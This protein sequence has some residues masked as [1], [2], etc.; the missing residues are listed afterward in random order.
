MYRAFIENDGEIDLD[1]QA[2]LFELQ[3]ELGLSSEQVATIEANVRE[4]LAIK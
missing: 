3:E 2:Q 4:E 1:E